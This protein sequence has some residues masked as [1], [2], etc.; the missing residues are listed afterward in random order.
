MD[1]NRKVRGRVIV[2]VL[3]LATV[4]LPL[5]LG[6]AVLAVL[7][8]D[9]PFELDG[10]ATDEIGPDAADDWDNLSSAFATT[11][12]LADGASPPADQTYFTRG[13]SKDINDISEWGHAAKDS[14]PD[15]DE[16]TN[17]YAAAYTADD[18]DLL[19]Y[20]GADRLA[21]NGDSQIGF[22]FLQDDIG[23]NPDGTFDGH[24]QEG[25]ILV[26]SEFV[27]GGSV[28]DVK[29]YQWEGPGGSEDSLTLLAHGADCDDLPPGEGFPVC[30]TV[31]NEPVPV[32]D[33][34]D[35]ESKSGDSTSFPTGAFYEGGMNLS[36]ILRDARQD[37]SASGSFSTFLAETR[38][39]QSV[40]AQLKDFV[41]GPFTMRVN[42][43]L[44]FAPFQSNRKQS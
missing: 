1:R 18:G 20:F 11:G 28:F 15:K 3:S 33:L 8:P 29:V 9:M 44:F 2:R 37:I 22:W 32:P 16:L 6:Q 7:W 10:N 24:H 21:N 23:L 5:L 27:K 14:A 26:M 19:L 40:D 17:A 39:S 38:S 41:L 35:Y 12:I 42:L 43:S 34:W 30:A 31:N 36:A 4:L 25:D 13:G